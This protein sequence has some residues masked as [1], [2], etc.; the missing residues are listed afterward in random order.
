[1]HA[2]ISDF[3]TGSRFLQCQHFQA[4]FGTFESQYG[5]HL[6]VSVLGGF[7]IEKPSFRLNGHLVEGVFSLWK[8]SSLFSEVYCLLFNIFETI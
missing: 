4:P 1:M 6:I 7:F 3:L 8:E 5:Q 2:M